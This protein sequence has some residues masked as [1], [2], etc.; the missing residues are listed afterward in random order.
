MLQLDHVLHLDFV[1]APALEFLANDTGE[2]GGKVRKAGESGAGN[3]TFVQIYEAGCVS[4]QAVPAMLD[5]DIPSS[6]TW[7]PMINPRLLW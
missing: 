2:V 6:A 4:T 3:V 1:N 7:L 5:A